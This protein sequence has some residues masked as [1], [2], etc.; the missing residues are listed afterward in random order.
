MGTSVA[1][2]VAFY[3]DGQKQRVGNLKFQQITEMEKFDDQVI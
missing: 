3:I 1:N 2:I